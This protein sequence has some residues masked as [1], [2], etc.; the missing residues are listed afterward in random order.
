[1]AYQQEVVEG[2]NKLNTVGFV[3]SVI[4]TL[5]VFTLVEKH[6]LGTQ[7][8]YV[9][10]AVLAFAQ[11]FVQAKCFLWSLLGKD[12]GGWNMISFLFTMLVMTVLIGGS[13][14]IMYNLNYNMMH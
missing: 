9:V 6:M 14:W 1:M 12:E 13:L 4:L 8:L 11:A 5:L 3:L 2:G 10:V 7:A